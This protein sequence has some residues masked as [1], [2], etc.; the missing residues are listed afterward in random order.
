MTR[1]SVARIVTSFGS[2]WGRI[3]PR[4]GA[5]EVFFTPSSL[6]DPDEFHG[7]KVG[8]YVEFDEENDRI[9]GTRA[10][11]VTRSQRSPAVSVPA[12]P[13]AVVDRARRKPKERAL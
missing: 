9:N 4:D 1:G 8:E 12:A 6:R 2:E 11:N 13:P 7:L 5:R 3:R 10:T